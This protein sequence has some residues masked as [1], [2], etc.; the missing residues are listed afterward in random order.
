MSQSRQRLVLIAIAFTMTAIGAALKVAHAPNALITAAWMTA[1]GIGT[2]GLII[3]WSRRAGDVA[4]TAAVEVHQGLGGVPCA[5]PCEPPA[6]GTLV[7][8]ATS[9]VWEP[10]KRALASGQSERR[11]DHRVRASTTFD[12]VLVGIRRWPAVII[13]GADGQLLTLAMS[14]QSAARL[15]QVLSANHSESDEG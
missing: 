7:V 8:T 1:V 4:A 2:V 3:W 13:T 15:K 12:T 11:I 9:Y 10:N 5:V 6:W 14:K